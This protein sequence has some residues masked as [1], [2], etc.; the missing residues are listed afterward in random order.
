VPFESNSY[1][2]SR[3]C[4]E[5]VDADFQILEVLKTYDDEVASRN[6]ASKAKG[7]LQFHFDS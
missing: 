6:A 5:S 2:V 7:L 3:L 1:L 4:V